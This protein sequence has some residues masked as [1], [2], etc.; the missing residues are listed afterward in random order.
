MYQVIGGYIAAGS[1]K[2]SGEPVVTPV[3]YR[4]AMD[5]VYDHFVDGMYIFESSNLPIPDE[6]LNDIP[7]PYHKKVIQ[8]LESNHHILIVTDN[9][10]Y[11]KVLTERELENIVDRY[12]N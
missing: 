4:L 5:G 12:S 1:G 11:A 10:V 8:S 6:Y 2:F 9:A 3:L 7:K